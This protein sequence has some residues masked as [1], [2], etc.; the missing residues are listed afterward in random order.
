M[1]V[2]IDAD[3]TAE[4]IR[5]LT[6]KNNLSAKE[7]AIELNVTQMCIYN[8]LLGNN[9]PSIENLIALSILFSVSINE[10]V[11]YELN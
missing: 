4:N 6:Y 3:K 8:W 10:I 1:Y 11:A 7:L 2:M 9:L 5:R